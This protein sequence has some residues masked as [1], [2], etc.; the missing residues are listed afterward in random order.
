MLKTRRASPSAW[1]CPPVILL[2]GSV[3]L[4]GQSGPR[5]CPGGAERGVPEESPGGAV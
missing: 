5:G 3:V 4:I 1:G 2:I